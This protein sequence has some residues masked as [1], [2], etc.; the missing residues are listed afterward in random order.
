[1]ATARE[2]SLARYIGA[3]KAHL[4]NKTGSA[5]NEAL[6]RRR[7][8][9]LDLYTALAL[10]LQDAQVSSLLRSS[11]VVIDPASPPKDVFRGNVTNAPLTAMFIGFFGSMTFVFIRTA[12]NPTFVV[13]KAARSQ[14]SGFRMNSHGPVQS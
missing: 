5:R 8:T 4:A 12:Q 10:R 3:Q 11:F 13:L 1:M 2:N 14:V 7:K 9:Y 6:E